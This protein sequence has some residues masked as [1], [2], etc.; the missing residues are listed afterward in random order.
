[1]TGGKAVL[2]WSA[3]A[4][5][6]ITVVW[7]FVLVGGPAHNRKLAAD[8]NRIEDLQQLRQQIE[9]FY[10]SNKRLPKAL[11]ELEQ[12][13]IYSYYQLPLVDPISGEDYIFRTTSSFKYSLCAEFALPSS[14]A[15]L[16]QPRYGRV[17]Q[18]WTYDA[19]RHCFNFE[20]SPKDRSDTKATGAPANPN[21]GTAR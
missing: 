19:G 13:P 16:E 14:E 3:I 20:I 8:K 1:M 5:V 4:V 6:G 2:K 11:K 17:K 21:R 10:R 15:S 18:F 12:E 7:A 9:Q